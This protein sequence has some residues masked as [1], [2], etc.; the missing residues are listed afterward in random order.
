[1]VNIA[2]LTK[3]RLGEILVHEG[4]VSEDQV[5]EALRCQATSGELLGE[6]LVKL[7][8]VSEQDIALTLANQF[9][10]PYIDASRYYVSRE[11]AEGFGIETL[12]AHRYVP[13]DRIGR[14]LIVAVSGPIEEKVFEEVEK[15]TKCQ[16]FLYV[17]TVSQ[18][19]QALKSGFQGAGPK[20]A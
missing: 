5:A 9:G 2:K 16:I 13:L 11:I 3:K 10:L 4:L 18:V 12:L 20:A 8:Y 6:L 15:R 1:M 14:I 17:S 19:L 7:G